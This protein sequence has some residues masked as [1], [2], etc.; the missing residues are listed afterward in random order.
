MLKEM[1]KLIYAKRKSI[2]AGKAPSAKR[3]RQRAGRDG[4]V[5]DGGEGDEAD[6]EEEDVDDLKGDEADGETHNGG[7][8]VNLE[9]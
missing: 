2:G 7:A 6:G 5:A 8:F 3:K 1:D 9:K 4:D